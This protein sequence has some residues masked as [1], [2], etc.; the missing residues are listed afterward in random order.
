MDKDSSNV[1]GLSVKS[2][3]ADV[4]MQF[5]ILLYLLDND[6]SVMILMSNALS[7]VLLV[8]KITRISDI[9]LVDRFPFIRIQESQAYAE[10]PTK[11]YDDYAIDKLTKSMFPCLAAYTVYS[12]VYC[13]H[14]SLYSFVV[15]TLVGAIYLFGFIKMTP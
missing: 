2:L 6:T 10:S 1:Q 11:M 3:Y 13:E 8:W 14:K 4:G 12:L 7:I 5:V 9:Y 15:N